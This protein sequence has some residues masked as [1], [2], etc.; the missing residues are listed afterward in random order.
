MRG[1][2]GPS[3]P[4]V[5]EL[6]RAR[7]LAALTAVDAVFLFEEPNNKVN[8]ELLRPDIYFK[9]GDYTKERLSSAATVEKFGGRVEIVSFEDGRS[10]SGIVDRIVRG[11]FDACTSF[12]ALPKGEPR[13]T[14]FV[15][16]DGTI[17]EH[18]EYLHEAEKIQFLPGAIDGLKLLTG[19]GVQIVVITNQPGIGL[20]YFTKEQF[21]SV[22]RA[23]LRV[24]GS[25][26][27]RIQKVYFCPHSHAEQCACRK[28]GLALIERAW[29]E[30]PVDRS[31]S[32]F[33]GD[34]TGDLECG[35]RANMR[36]VL[37][38]S[39][40]AG[41]DG[42]FK[43]APDFTCGT[44]VDAADLIRAQLSSQLPQHLGRG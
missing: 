13:P 30:L 25:A 24:L 38:T 10:T 44:L 14:A 20:G 34:M 35:R 43:V 36:T 23:M 19:M 29:D 41:A 1:L 9:A 42:L 39:G 16:R 17:I 7:V 28:P 31:Q 32:F 33:I 22:N 37:M 6:D 2:K 15:D 5:A 18:V 12:I 26:G 8:V 4:I 3:R 27:V 21:Y 40:E 11:G